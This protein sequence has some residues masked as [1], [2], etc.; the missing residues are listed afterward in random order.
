MNR[1]EAQRE[2]DREVK[3]R[4][5]R[6]VNILNEEFPIPEDDDELAQATDDDMIRG[7]LDKFYYKRM[8]EDNP[9]PELQE[10]CWRTPFIA[11]LEEMGE[12]KRAK[13]IEIILLDD[14]YEN[15]SLDILRILIERLGKNTAFTTKIQYLENKDAI[16]KVFEK[17]VEVMKNAKKQMGF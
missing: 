12:E 15:L 6:V 7:I 5:Q 1:E 10:Y 4:I 16:V 13:L 14:V 3:Q 11:N 17:G 8:S 9:Y 2:I